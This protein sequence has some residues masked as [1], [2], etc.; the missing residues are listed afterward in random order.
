MPVKRITNINISQRGLFTAIYGN[1][2]DYFVDEDLKKYSLQQQLYLYL[3]NE[4]YDI[5][6]FYDTNNRFHSYSKTDLKKFL[7]LNSAIKAQETVTVNKV[8]RASHIKSP[9]H[10]VRNTQ[11]APKPDAPVNFDDDDRYI[12]VKHMNANNGFW[13]LREN[14]AE[15]YRHM[16]RILTRNSK[17]VK[18][19]IIIRSP[20]STS[21]E[22]QENYATLFNNIKALYDS[23]PELRNRIIIIYDCQDA[24]SLDTHFGAYSDMLFSNAYFYNIFISQ[25]THPV[26]VNNDLTHFIDLPDEEEINH[27]VQRLRINEKIPLD[28]IEL[29]TIVK[30]LVRRELTTM[31]ISKRL[32]NTSLKHLNT[33][34][35]LENEIIIPL[36]IEIDEEVL[37]ANLNKVIGQSE[38]TPLITR[39][40]KAHFNLRKRENPLSFLLIGTSG[41]GKTFTA[42]LMAASLKKSG[43]RYVPLAMNLYQQE[44]DVNRLIGS[45]TGFVGSETPPKLFEELEKSSRLVILFDE[46]EKAHEKVITALM[47]L[48]DKGTLSWNEKEGDFRDCILIFTSNAERDRVVALKNEQLKNHPGNSI[49]ALLNTDFQNKLKDTLSRSGDGHQFRPEFC[50][51][52]NSF[53][54]YNPLKVPDLV[55]VAYE[56]IKSTALSQY[57]IQL[58]Y[59]TPFFLG[60]LASSF[61]ESSYGLRDLKTVVKDQLSSL[62]E[63]LRIDTKLYYQINDNH[64]FES[65]FLS[66]SNHQND[67]DANELDRLFVD[68]IRLANE[69]A[70]Q[71][72]QIDPHKVV[73]SLQSVKGQEDSFDYIA[74]AIATWI[75]RKSKPLN[76][77]FVGPSGVGKTET[78]KQITSTL[79]SQGYEIHIIT[80]NKLAHE[81]QINEIIGIF[82]NLLLYPPNCVI[83]IYT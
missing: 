46:I 52:I 75:R 8:Y 73:T 79:S 53:L 16:E 49:E 3:K 28:F 15:M 41:V 40:V 47:Q 43:Y 82:L 66:P 45:A 33:A 14:V 32:Y 34:E 7:N 57:D 67:L 83:I 24:V 12:E 1:W 44:H 26:K 25:R 56:Y 37:T 65:Q 71:K 70:K 29:Q 19:A 68:A 39:K 35:L 61:N 80:C 42:E 59:I 27:I 21:F 55:Q 74:D 69:L 5:V 81:A 22:N 51:R 9:L 18:S 31:E 54:V 23:N 72:K 50:G 20:G 2:E 77:F 17:D 60:K 4:N 58:N 64:G 6:L 78:A 11:Q 62:A 63:A 48:L 10:T 76:F 30:S 38:I 36:H 13:K